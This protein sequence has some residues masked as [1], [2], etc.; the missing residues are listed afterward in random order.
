MQTKKV[1]DKVGIRYVEMNLED[2]PE[3]VQEFIGLGLTAAPIVETD[4]KKWS[5]FRLS[6]I[7]S[8]ANHLFGD[9]KENA[10]PPQAVNA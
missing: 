7:N 3:K 8:L 10:F 2:H 1:M 9:K 6:K 4:I 5:G